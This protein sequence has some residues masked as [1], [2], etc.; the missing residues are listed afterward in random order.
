MNLHYNN[1]SLFLFIPLVFFNFLFSFSTFASN[2]DLKKSISSSLF[3]PYADITVGAV[4]NDWQNY[5]EGRPSDLVPISEQTGTKGYVLAFIQSIEGK[6]KAGWAGVSA[7][8]ID[9]MWGKYLTDQL[10]NN[11][12]NYSISFGGASGMDLSAACSSA[13]DLKNIYEQVFTTFQPNALDFDIEGNF[14]GDVK[15]ITRMMT[16]L[17][18]F[19]QDHPDIKITLTLPTMPEGLT[20]LGENIIFIAKN[21]GL[22]FTVNIMAMDYGSTYNQDM[23]QYAIQASN[24]L[25]LFLKTQFP[26]KAEKDLWSMV[27]VTQMIGLNDISSE[28]FTINDADTVNNFSKEKG[29]GGVHMWSVARDNP[30]S[31]QWA[32]PICSGIINQTKYEYMKHFAK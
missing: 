29:M 4:W 1:K 17:N 6:C 13:V 5:P 30:C 31:I 19:Q 23:A 20:S 18:I 26:S 28:I 22:N 27:E 3:S 32:S 9:S 25:F 14:Q 2:S 12:I 7:L 11:K 21:S 10:T 16:A 8:S 24:N 15:S